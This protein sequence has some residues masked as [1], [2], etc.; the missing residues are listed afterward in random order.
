MVYFKRHKV[1]IVDFF[2]CLA[3]G[4]SYVNIAVCTNYL[5]Y[6]ESH[7]FVKKK[8]WHTRKERK[9]WFWLVFL[10]TEYHQYN[11]EIT[12][13]KPPYAYKL[14]VSVDYLDFSIC[15]YMTTNWMIWGGEEFFIYIF[16]ES[17][18]LLNEDDQK[19]SSGISKF[20]LKRNR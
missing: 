6:L 20:E 5:E 13:T 1:Q 15:F 11:R 4:D 2:S 10:N 7:S 19:I 18:N 16:F 12:I 14:Y 17:D 3:T 9:D 8:T